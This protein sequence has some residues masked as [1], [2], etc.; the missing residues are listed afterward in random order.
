MSLIHVPGRHVRG[1]GVG[2]LPVRTFVGGM[3]VPVWGMNIVGGWNVT[4][5]FVRLS[6]FREGLRVN[7]ARPPLSLLVPRWEATYG[8]LQEVAAVG[9]IEGIT[10]GVLFRTSERGGWVVF[11]TVNRPEVLRALAALGVP[12]SSSP[13]RFRYFHPYG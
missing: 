4:Y 3:R 9:K 2:E 11:W 10:S 8:E 1:L 5:P 12:V 7:A 13:R 6:L